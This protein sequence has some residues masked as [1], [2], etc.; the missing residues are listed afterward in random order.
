MLHNGCLLGSE[1]Q[2]LGQSKGKQKSQKNSARLP[3][4]T[5]DCTGYISSALKYHQ[6][7]II[8]EWKRCLLFPFRYFKKL[9]GKTFCNSLEEST[10]TNREVQDSVSLHL[11]TYVSSGRSEQLMMGRPISNQP[12]GWENASTFKPTSVTLLMHTSL[13][14]KT[15]TL[16]RFPER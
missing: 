16:A 5:A 3:D 6:S 8:H 7:H 1:R 10:L 11:I 9:N 2:Q 12:H 13:G 4:I 14:A 15:H